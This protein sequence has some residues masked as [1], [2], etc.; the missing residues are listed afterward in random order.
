MHPTVVVMVVVVGI[1]VGFR[2][3]E[4]QIEEFTMTSAII[5]SAVR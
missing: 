1:T 2:R 4:E 3:C 5:V